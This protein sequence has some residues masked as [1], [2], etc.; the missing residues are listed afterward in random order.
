MLGPRNSDSPALMGLSFN[1][2]KGKHN[3]F[4]RD[5][6]KV[7]DLEICLEGLLYGL[8]TIEFISDPLL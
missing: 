6:G 4:L 2:F 7:G 3:V 5:R 8:Q 1:G